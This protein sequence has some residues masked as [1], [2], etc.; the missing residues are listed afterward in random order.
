MTEPA[1]AFRLCPAKVNLALSVG[2]PPPPPEGEGDGYH[3]IASWMVTIDLCD[4]LTLT[5]LDEGPS[6]F[7]IEW[8]AD[9][10]QPTPIDWPIETDLAYRAHRRVG[11]HVGRALPVRMSLVKR[12][13][14]GAGL[15]GGSTDGA[16]M[17]LAL[18]DLFNLGLS[19]EALIDLA[20]RLGS[21]VA[22]FLAEGGSAIVTGLGQTLTPAPLEQPIDLV[23]VMPP[24]HCPTGRVYGAF[25]RLCADAAVDLPGVREVHAGR[26]EPFNDL[27][28]AACGVEPRLKDLKSQLSALTS[29]PVHITGSGAGLFILPAEPGE[30]EDLAATIREQIKVPA[31]A[32]R[33]VAPLAR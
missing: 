13:P 5:R 2:V 17:L 16:G 1:R 6:A 24:L 21:D 33:T 31:I 23:L 27:A 19:H 18:N 30:A 7:D 26:R 29:L 8:A 11:E 32:T 28:E 14:T 4:E 10:P 12:I 3:P 25:D 9:A 20:M 22:F 15:A